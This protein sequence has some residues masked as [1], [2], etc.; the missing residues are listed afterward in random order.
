MFNENQNH[1]STI[2]TQVI[3]TN[4]IYDH[5]RHLTTEVQC[6][7]IWRKSKQPAQR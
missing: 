3:L 5:Q 4:K 1:G 7:E 2:F 6:E